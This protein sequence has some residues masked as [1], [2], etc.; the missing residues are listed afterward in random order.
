VQW[1]GRQA[2]VTLP[3]HIDV[4]NADQIREELP[5]V[6]DRGAAALI[7][8]MTAALSCDHTGADAVGRAYQRAVANGT[9]LRLVVT[10]RIVRRVLGLNGLDRLIPIYPSLEAAITAGAPHGG[11]PSGRAGQSRHL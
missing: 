1:T 8:D 5:A 6:I 2:V 7:M 10:A 4:S 3:D 9:Q 11:D